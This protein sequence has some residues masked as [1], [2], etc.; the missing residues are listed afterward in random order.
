MEN[1]TKEK[2]EAMNIDEIVGLLNEK[3]ST[4]NMY[5]EALEYR[6][7]LYNEVRAKMDIVRSVINL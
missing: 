1:Y 2:V 5:R 6:A 3:E 7:K 4:L